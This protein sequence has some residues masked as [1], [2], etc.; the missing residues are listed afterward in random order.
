MPEKIGYDSEKM[1]IKKIAQTI[2]LRTII[3]SY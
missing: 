1:S 3:F 2:V